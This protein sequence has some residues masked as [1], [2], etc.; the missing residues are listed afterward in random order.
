[1]STWSSRAAKRQPQRRR[2]IHR[3]RLTK[4]SGAWGAITAVIGLVAV[5][6][7]TT[8]YV[9]AACIGLVGTIIVAFAGQSAAVPTRGT[10]VRTTRSPGGKARTRKTPANPGTPTKGGK[11][12]H[13]CRTSTAAKSTC[14][15]RSATCGHGSQ[16]GVLA[17]V[18]APKLP[19]K[20][21]LRSKQA[22]QQERSV[23][24]AQR[25]TK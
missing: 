13:R 8:G 18:S 11:C 16:S 15:C 25:G 22:R 2:K 23:V 20:S 5:T 24:R 14:R 6:V 4:A 19:T 3:P 1:M 17:S 21:Q 9:V 10:E 12:S 7:Q